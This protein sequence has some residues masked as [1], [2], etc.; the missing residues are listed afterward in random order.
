M[1]IDKTNLR[2]SLREQ[3]ESPIAASGFTGVTKKREKWQAYINYKGKRYFLGC[4]EKLEDAVNARA[5]AKQLVM[6]DAEKLLEFYQK[7]NLTK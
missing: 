2:Q 3:V 6:E 1:N 7:S 4:Y 5:R